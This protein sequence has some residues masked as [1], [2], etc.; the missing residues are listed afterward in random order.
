[1]TADLKFFQNVENSLCANAFEED[2]RIKIPAK[3]A[4]PRI[5]RHGRQARIDANEFSSDKALLVLIGVIRRHARKTATDRA[6]DDYNERRQ[7]SQLFLVERRPNF[8]LTR[9]KIDLVELAG[10]EIPDAPQLG[11][12]MWPGQVRFF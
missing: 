11:R 7:R 6:G 10:K 12:P 4:R 1:M 8:Y 3:K 5:T 2:N 9:S